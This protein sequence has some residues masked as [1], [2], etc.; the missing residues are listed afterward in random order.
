MSA[1]KRQCV[2]A[3]VPN[4]PLRLRE[5][6][7]E[8]QARVLGF[9]AQPAV[10]LQLALSC[11]ALYDMVMR[12]PAWAASG[13]VGGPLFD[14]SPVPMARALAVLLYGR[15]ELCRRHDGYGGFTWSSVFCVYAHN[16]CLSRQ[17]TRGFHLTP[18]NQL[19]RVM[20]ARS[21]AIHQDVWRDPK[22]AL[23]WKCEHA[24][25]APHNTVEGAEV[26]T[27]EQ[28]AA[29]GNA[30]WAVDSAQRALA[31]GARAVSTARVA[32]AVV[33]RKEKVAA[34]TL[35]RRNAL[36][37]ALAVAALPS[38]ALLG[39][40]KACVDS[41]LSPRLSTPYSVKEAVARVRK[42]VEAASA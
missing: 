28:A 13:L 39:D 24:L 30:Y 6:P 20:A 23:Y 3:P 1:R 26:L 4:T 10:L 42:C 15:C 14:A 27:I 37:A 5:L 22:L 19:P 25:I 40:Q 12:M 7:T 41:F 36:E 8:L 18:K 11:H 38:L 34:A 2:R 21:L 9:V 29:A 35:K 17:L 32:S 16:D 31:Q 33:A